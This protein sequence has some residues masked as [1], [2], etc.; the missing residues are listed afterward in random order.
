[1][2]TI[3]A[4]L[5]TA[6]DVYQFSIEIHDVDPSSK[7]MV[8]D[9]DLVGFSDGL[10][11]SIHQMQ[12]VVHST[13]NSTE[14]LL[15]ACIKIGLDISVHLDHVQTSFS[16]PDVDQIDATKFR[17]L[18][19]RE[20]VDALGSRLSEFTKW[21][22][23][24][25]PVDSA[26]NGLTQAP[27]LSLLSL[28]G[29]TPSKA[30]E[31]SAADPDALTGAKSSTHPAKDGPD[32]RQSNSDPMFNTNGSNTN[33]SKGLK[34]APTGI[35]NDFLLDALAYKSMHDREEE[36]TEAHGQTLEWIFDG[37]VLD[38]THRN[39]FRSQFTSWL[40][41]PDLG[42]IYWITGKPGSGKSTL[43]RFLSQHPVAM[44]QLQQWAKKRPVCT[45]GFFF[46]TSGSQEQR[47]QTGLLRY[48]LHQLLSANPELI[49]STFPALWKR[50]RE[51]TTKERISLTLEWTVPDLMAAFHSLLDIALPQMNIC[52]FI[53]GLDEFDGNH[54]EIVEFFKAISAGENGHAIKMC[55]S[56]RP[57]SVFEGAFQ[58]SVPNARLQ[59][60][61]YEDMH[62]YARDQLRRNVSVRRLF[63]NDTDSGHELVEA[64]VQRADGVFLW[65]RLAVERMLSLFQKDNT[66]KS[67]NEMLES[68]PRDLDS[69]FNKL[70]FEDQT[71]TQITGAAVLFQLMC[72]RELV[73]NFIK[74]ESSTSLTVWELAFALEETDDAVALKRQ[75]TEASDKE[76]VA[77][78]EA[79]AAHVLI[80]FSGLMSL[81]RRRRLGNLR[82]TKF[83]DQN[84]RVD[85]A[86]SLA[87]H[88]VTYIHRTVRDW[89]M[90]PAG[91]YDRLHSIRNASFDPHLRLLRSYVL[92]LKYPLEEI[93]QHRR[94]DEW[95]PDIALAMSH[96]RYIANDSK[97][98]QRPFLNAMEK[99]LSW[100]WLEKPS[101]PFDHWARNTFGSYEVRMKAP[102][103]RHPFIFLAAK[104]G[105][106]EYVVGELEENIHMRNDGLDDEMA[107]AKEPTPLL[108]YA[109]EFL[110]SRNKTIF[111]L[112]DP[113]LIEYLVTHSSDV[114][115][116]PNHRYTDFNTRSS[117]TPWLA[118]LCHLRDA[119]RRGWIE[120]YDINPEGT[121][122]WT[123]IARLFI[124][125]GGSDVSAV[126]VAT[127]WDP[128]VTAL[129]VFE[130]LEGAYGAVEV[131]RIRTLLTERQQSL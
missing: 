126:V 98:L 6:I 60:L 62:R 112:S 111:P 25:Q 17:V 95:Y 105:L 76:I 83:S 51:M 32:G 87:D 52:L 113:R 35:V 39:D 61:T 49:P 85:N 104:F 122:R 110:C 84:H 56:S 79:T 86:R 31:P 67:L 12:D 107:D 9:R 65:V 46:W 22:K 91:A 66:I 78:C 23:D 71:E 50:L 81:H 55:L 88:K 115:P 47:S 19:R 15:R 121:E 7:S 63:K 3:A 36:V 120:H 54:N 10:S 2:D 24:L 72:A 97:H 129:G 44:N 131:Q 4:F 1:M 109:T 28:H 57:W 74:D 5:K 92:R 13:A 108:A 43:V 26:T 103:I 27:H 40:K 130:L 58:R 118:L 53:D 100:Y 106:T 119:H 70:I 96:A 48:L 69:F 94:L 114:N 90:D 82:A 124:E 34:L 127:N 14:G 41:T 8:S 16:S 116:G 11:L 89:L 29:P 64:T 73:A 99:T 101:D 128:E 37:T 93:E 102:P 75:V 42:S 18:W 125:A 45:A 77:R 117:T 20:N 68:F 30:V 33:R 123:E 38:D 21:W 80:G 59:D